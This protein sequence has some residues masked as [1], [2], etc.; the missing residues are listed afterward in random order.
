[1]NLIFVDA[2]NVGLNTIQE[3]DTRITDKVFVFSNNEQIKILC[4]DLMFIMVDGYP[5]GKNQADFYLIAHLRQLRKLPY[6]G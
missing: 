6:I 1:M 5:I 4:H 3:I 2:E